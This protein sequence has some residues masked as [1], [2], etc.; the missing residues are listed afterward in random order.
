MITIYTLTYNEEALIEFFIN[1]YRKRFPNCQINVFDNYST[2]K[3]VE[4]TKKN[5]CNV[6]MYDTNNKLSDNKYLEIKNNCWKE[7]ST[8]WVIVCDCDELLDITEEELIQEDNKG[9]TIISTEAYD[10]INTSKDKNII[11]LNEIS[12]GV[13]ENL[14]DKKIMFKSKLINEINYHHGCHSDSPN[15]KIVLSHKKY[16]LFHYKY[17]SENY[18][19]DRYKL[20]NERLS[21]DNKKYGWGT[22]Y[23]QN[24][25]QIRKKFDDLRNKSEK[26]I[27]K[28]EN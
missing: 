28:N 5:D 16:K 18:V 11:N 1:H 2:D 7:S 23:S 24:E 26:I 13:R 8:D 17:I 15:G 3:T 19:I 14:Y 12:K 21:E 9:T 6:I 20:F 10:M 22:H 25:S 4:I 27:E